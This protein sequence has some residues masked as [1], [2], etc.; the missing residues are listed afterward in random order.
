MGESI[1]C[2]QRGAAITC[3]LA[4]LV[5]SMPALAAEPRLQ[6]GP[7]VGYQFGGSLDASSEYERRHINILDAP[8]FGA[9]INFAA[10]RDGIAEIGYSRTDTE[11]TVHSSD[12]SFERYDLAINYLTIGGLLEFR[13]PGAE[14]LRPVIG[15]TMGPSWFEANN[16][17]YSYEE[18]RF[19]LLLEGGLEMQVVDHLGLRFRARLLTTFFT[20]HSA[21]F[22]GTG[23][24][25]AF[26]FSGTALFQGEVGAGV[27]EAF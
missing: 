14:W 17:Y 27:Y 22:C 5:A 26:T 23:T 15:G 13:I 4:L 12:G 10:A 16:E 18:W 6:I 8:S 21:L 25:C 20:D 7:Y 1:R 11:I 3:G 19:S 24:G 2:S 9:T